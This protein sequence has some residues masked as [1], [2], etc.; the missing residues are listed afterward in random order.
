MRAAVVL[1]LLALAAVLGAHLLPLLL[2]RPP[3]LVHAVEL[4]PV[5]GLLGMGGALVMRCWRLDREGVLRWA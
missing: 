4:A 2:A 5:A 3:V 1:V